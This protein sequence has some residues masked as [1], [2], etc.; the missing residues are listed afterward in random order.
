MTLVGILV[1]LAAYAGAVALPGPGIA[2]LI[3]RV[4]ARGHGGIAAYLAGFL[5]GDLVWF[6]LAATGLA[7]IAATF[8]PLI[9]AIRFLGAGYLLY[10]AFRLVT[11]RREPL[12][13]EAQVGSKGPW[14]RDFASSLS[15]TLGNPK[16]ITFF[17]ALLPTVIDLRRLDVSTGVVLGLLMGLTQVVILGGYALLASR[18]RKMFHSRKAMKALDIGTGAVMA[19]AAVV[20]ATR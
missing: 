16:A 6:G 2:A 18:T 15:L 19:G 12:D 10:L 3:A 11:T 13:A 8:A 9:V 1:Y 17:L 20:V 7:A 5:V 4:L 14:T